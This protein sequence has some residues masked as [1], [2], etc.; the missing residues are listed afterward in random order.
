MDGQLSR[1]VFNSYKKY[2]SINKNNVI[3]YAPI[4]KETKDEKRKT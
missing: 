2:F 4:E 1:N 3:I